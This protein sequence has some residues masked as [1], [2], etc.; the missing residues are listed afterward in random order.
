VTLLYRD[1]WEKKPLV[2]HRHRSQHNDSWF[3][4]KEMDRILREVQVLTLVTS[5]GNH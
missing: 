3:S 5:L 2:I 4:T 1:I